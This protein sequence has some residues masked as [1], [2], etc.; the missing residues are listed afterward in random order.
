[1]NC[2]AI[3]LSHGKHLNSGESILFDSVSEHFLID[4]GMLDSSDFVKEHN[5]ER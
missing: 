1:M 5:H 2:E 3:A 4:S